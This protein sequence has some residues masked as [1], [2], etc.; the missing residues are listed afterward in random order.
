MTKLIFTGDVMIGRLV[1]DYLKATKKY[2]SIWG[3]TKEILESADLTFINLEYAL[4]KVAQRGE[5]QAPVFFFRSEPE[6]VRALLEAGVDY[7]ALANNHT[8]DFGIEGL[9]ETLQT[10]D[11]NKISS[12]GAGKNL[13][14]AQMAADLTVDNLKIKVFSF[15]D[16]EPGW[17]AGKEKP[18]IFYLPIDLNDKR[19][20]EFIKKIKL[21]KQESCFVIVAAHWGPNMV[22]VPPEH[23]RRFARRLIDAGVDIFWGHSSHVF[24]AVEI[25]K[26]KVIFYDCGE[27]VDDYAVD[28]ILRNDESFIFEV[29]VDKSKVK[30]INLIPTHIDRL[31]VNIARG[32]YGKMISKKMMT[33]CQEFKTP[34]SMKKNKLKI[35]VSH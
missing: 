4:T 13:K 1:N 18:G 19:V 25:Y 9:L 12:S 16:N 27:L 30:E 10:L 29:L 32:R 34:V 6:H 8:L 26:E 3:N 2:A 28:P 11:K 21:A 24:Q 20:K 7:C 35:T 5:K 17:E 15:T 22:R 23:H 31:K 14:E 33:L